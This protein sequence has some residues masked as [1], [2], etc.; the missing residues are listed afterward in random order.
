MH[1]PSRTNPRRRYPREDPCWSHL[2]ESRVGGFGEGNSSVDFGDWGFRDKVWGWFK[3]VRG[4]PTYMLFIDS[5]WCSHEVGE[6]GL[7]YDQHMC[8]FRCDPTY[9]LFS[10]VRTP[11][12][13]ESCARN[14]FFSSLV[15]SCLSLFWE[16][17]QTL[18]P[19]SLWRLYVVSFSLSVCDPDRGYLSRCSECSESP[20]YPPKRGR[21]SLDA[22]QGHVGGAHWRNPG[23]VHAHLRH[24]WWRVGRLV[25][26]SI[27]SFFSPCEQVEFQNWWQRDCLVE[28]APASIA[29]TQEPSDPRAHVFCGW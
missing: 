26:G 9:V 17:A 27:F 18:I 13:A 11:S 3:R 21:S 16:R 1:P 20:W 7:R 25:C 28:D 15:L 5:P 4:D 22:C 24:W 6:K 10:L 19:H 23:W 14:P 8:F 29:I 2:D 12:L